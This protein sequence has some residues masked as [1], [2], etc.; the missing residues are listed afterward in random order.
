MRGLI[1]NLVATAVSVLLFAAVG[2]YV[3]SKNMPPGPE[4]IYKVGEQTLWR[5]GF[6]DELSVL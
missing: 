3:Y 2:F 6:S 1:F 4:N 5:D